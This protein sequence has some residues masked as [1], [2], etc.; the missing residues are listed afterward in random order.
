MDEA[1]LPGP[2]QTG[3]IIVP[4]L[5]YVNSMEQRIEAA[6]ATAPAWAKIGMTMPSEKMR[7]RAMQELAVHIAES[8]EKPCEVADRNQ[9]PL[10]L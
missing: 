7:A 5:F 1:W 9:L 8:L 4:P 2:A 6:L 10:P 3:L